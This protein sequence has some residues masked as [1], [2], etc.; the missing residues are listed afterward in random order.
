[1]GVPLGLFLGLRRGLGCYFPGTTDARRATLSFAS[2]LTADME[3]L[4][5]GLPGSSSLSLSSAMLSLATEMARAFILGLA[6][7]PSDLIGK[8]GDYGTSAK[9]ILHSR[10]K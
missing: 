2:L 8:M 1:M 7:T 9:T 3:K 10:Y 6:P 4:I 5:P